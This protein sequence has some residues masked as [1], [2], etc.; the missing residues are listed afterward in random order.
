MT[1]R[2]KTFSGPVAGLLAAFSTVLVLYQTPAWA[3]SGTEALKRRLE[4]LEKEVKELRM[5]LREQEQAA[6]TKKEVQTNKEEVAKVLH[7]HSEWK[8]AE[9]VVHLAGYGDATFVAP[10]GEDS[11]FEATFNPIFHFQFNDKL[12]ME[13]EVEI[14]LNEDGDADVVLEYA[15]LD[16]FLNDYTTL[17]AGRFLSP[18]GQFRQNGHPSWINKLPSHPIG[19]GD[20][21]A[22]LLNDIGVQARGGFIAGNTAMNYAVYVGNGPELRFE[23]SDG[24][25]EPELA[26]EGYP[27]DP[28]NNKVLG[29]RFG[30]RPIPNLEIGASGGLGQVPV[31]ESGELVA[32]EPQRDW[33][34]L[35]VDAS[36]Q[37]GGKLD[38]RAEWIQ[39][40]VDADAGSALL[41]DQMTWEAWYAQAAYK[42]L[43]TKFEGVVRYGKLD[44]P[45]TSDKQLAFGINYLIASNII[46]KLAYESNDESPDRWLAQFAYGY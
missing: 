40:R 42:F 33:R 29:G 12:M 10:K 11:H 20:G 38:L 16:Y 26:S 3:D 44:T 25:I 23:E 32:G 22:V 34:V 27:Q 35:G 14:E 2:L 46:V 4:T 1:A 7:E 21:G 9:S 39:Q 18:I 28:G 30:V 13:S 45:S 24:E 6:A 8:N 37:L 19:F 43:P 36:Y 41:P 15:S 17:V 5:L 31:S